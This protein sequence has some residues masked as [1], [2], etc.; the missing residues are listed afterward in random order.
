MPQPRICTCMCAW[1][2]QGP[3]RRSDTGGRGPGAT[4]ASDRHASFLVRVVRLSRSDAALSFLGGLL[5]PARPAPAG[6]CRCN[7]HLAQGHGMLQRAAGMLHAHV[8]RGLGSHNRTPTHADH[9]LAS[10][11]RQ[12]WHGLGS[13]EGNSTQVD[14]GCRPTA[15]CCR[16]LAWAKRRA[17]RGL[18]GSAKGR[19]RLPLGMVEN[20]SA[21]HAAV[22]G[23]SQ[24]V[25]SLRSLT[26][27][28]RAAG[29]DTL[30]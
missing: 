1:P 20:N 19:R 5:R 15:V 27:A 11:Q 13:S 23:T 18:P 22:N 29:S 8:K 17:P 26:A 9:A 25:R 6:T 24:P 16:P 10:C 28:R 14:V 30:L 7:A 4:V 12:P 3:R 21:A 2:S